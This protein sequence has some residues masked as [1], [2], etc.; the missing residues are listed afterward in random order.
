MP[1]NVILE[2][3]APELDDVI[4]SVL[5]PGGS[6]SPGR[7]EGERTV[8]EYY[9][10]VVGWF[11]VRAATSTGGHPD[12]ARE[13]WSNVP[14]PVRANFYDPDDDE[15]TIL[16]IDAFNGL[17]DNRVSE[18]ALQ[19]WADTLSQAGDR[20]PASDLPT[21]SFLAEDGVLEDNF[22]LDS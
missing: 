17:A 15:V 18:E 6:D 12:F 1:K 8:M 5:F 3:H 7:I 21:L 4:G 2:D 14:L 11:T 9:G 19:Y 13:A 22:L 20:F 10:E 16:A